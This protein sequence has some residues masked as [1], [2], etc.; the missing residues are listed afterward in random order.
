MSGIILQSLF[1]WCLLSR[2]SWQKP[3]VEKYIWWLK[4]N[5]EFWAHGLGQMCVDEREHC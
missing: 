3:E 5:C 1:D 4:I 2:E